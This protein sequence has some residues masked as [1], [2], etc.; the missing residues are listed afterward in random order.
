MTRLH[1]RDTDK[2]QLCSLVNQYLPGV[3]V[4]VYG[5]RINGR[6][7]DGSDLDVVLRSE[8]LSALDYDQLQALRETLTESDIPILV[9][10]RDWAALPKTFHQEITKAYVEL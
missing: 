4:W 3:S 10:L 9:D 7:H 5:S 6:S 8:D 2:Q 1:L